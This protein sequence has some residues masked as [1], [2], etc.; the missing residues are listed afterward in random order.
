[1]RVMGCAVAGLRAGV[2]DRTAVA[3]VAPAM[4][5]VNARADC[6]DHNGELRR[7]RVADVRRNG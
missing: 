4:W 6:D 5:P 7:L 2:N 3:E 1:M